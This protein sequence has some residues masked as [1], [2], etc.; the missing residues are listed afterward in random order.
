MLYIL[1]QEEFDQRVL[2]LELDDA[3]SA[4]EVAREMISGKTVEGCRTGYCDMCP[5]SHIGG[6]NRPSHSVS[7]LIC[8]LPRN[9]HK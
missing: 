4:L 9:Y 2:K 6:D 3:N 5:V 7:G 8:K 1:S